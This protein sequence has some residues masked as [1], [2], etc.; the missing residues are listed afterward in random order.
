MEAQPFSIGEALSFG[1]GVVKKNIGFFILLMIV[2]Y[3]VSYLPSVFGVFIAE[4]SM[5]LYMLISIAGTILGF[6]ISIG[7]MHITIK[8]ADGQQGGWNDLFARANLWWKF[9]LGSLLYGLIV[10]A[11]MILLIIP[12]IIWAIKYSQMFYII[13]D[14]QIGPL[15][16][17]KQS[18]QMTAGVKGSLFLFWIVAGLVNLLGFLLF[19]VGSFVTVPIT[20]VAMAHV[21]RKL[22]QRVI[23]MA[24]PTNPPAAV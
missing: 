20:Y 12:G 1:W 22:S 21:Y 13:V 11:G 18:G 23:P 6:I 4:E 2:V 16:A 24:S 8:F 9:L 17:L 14:K 5:F 7:F 15:E 3:A 19:L 10:M